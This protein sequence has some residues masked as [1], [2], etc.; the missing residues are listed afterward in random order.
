VSLMTC[1]LLQ[2]ALALR[3][4]K[5]L[6]TDAPWRYDATFESTLLSPT[7]RKS[8]LPLYDTSITSALRAP[9]DEGAD[10]VG[11]RRLARS[12]TN[13]NK[14]PT[15]VVNWRGA[16][17]KSRTSATARTAAYNPLL[18][19]RRGIWE[20]RDVQN[21]GASSASGSRKAG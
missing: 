12:G 19:V 17:T 2:R 6:T 14:P 15:L 1:G 10:R 21:V 20:V 11:E 16:S 8:G 7:A 3:P 18:E 9:V 4:M 5:M 13:R